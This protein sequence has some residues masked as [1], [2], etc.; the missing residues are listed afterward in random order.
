MARKK[1]V[2][3]GKDRVAPYQII[4]FV[5]K[6]FGFGLLLLSFALGSL[7]LGL[8]VHHFNQVKSL[9]D[10]IRAQEL[11]VCVKPAAPSG[12][13]ARA[14]EYEGELLVSWDSVEYVTGYV[15]RVESQADA[16]DSLQ[17]PVRAE[18]D[19]MSVRGLNPGEMYKVALA[20]ENECGVGEESGVIM[21]MARV[22]GA[23]VAQQPVVVSQDDE[24]EEEVVVAIA[25]ETRGV[26]ASGLW[27]SQITEVTQAGMTFDW[28]GALRYAM[29]E[30]GMWFM[31]GAVL[32]FMNAAWLAFYSLWGVGRGARTIGGSVMGM[33]G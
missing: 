33:R 24:D 7:S 4:R 20:S 28:E 6:E 26:D 31:V 3:S 14:G 17:V 10:R 32:L 22:G 21:G 19:R 1:K 12:V 15:L 27:G 2:L 13:V 5:V 8:S 29:Y 30:Q 18:S 23:D 16:A 25:D 9:D 11:E